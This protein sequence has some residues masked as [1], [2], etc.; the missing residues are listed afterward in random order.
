MSDRDPV[1][2]MVIIVR[3]TPKAYLVCESEEVDGV[4]M[5]KSQM[6]E[7]NEVGRTESDAIV[8]D[9]RLNRSGPTGFPIVEMEIPEW[10]AEEKGLI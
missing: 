3:E 4:W 1:E 9:K 10:L 5:P 8:G 2:V 7:F 6:G